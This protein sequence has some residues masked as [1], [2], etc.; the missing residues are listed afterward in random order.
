MMEKS[1]RKLKTRPK[2]RK[3]KKTK[4]DRY[5]FPSCFVSKDR[6]LC[7]MGFPLYRDVFLPGN[8]D[9]EVVESKPHLSICV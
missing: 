8:E 9:M 2:S 4:N 5:S 7:M 1:K 6:G 3:K